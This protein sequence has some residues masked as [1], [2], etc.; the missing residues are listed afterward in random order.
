VSLADELAAGNDRVSVRVYSVTG[1]LV[2]DLYQGRATGDF[3]VQWDGSDDRGNRVASTTYYA[4]V[5]AGGA[6][7]TLKLV[8]LK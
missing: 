1:A 3:V 6:K 2:R 5:T 7:E 8:L 4:V